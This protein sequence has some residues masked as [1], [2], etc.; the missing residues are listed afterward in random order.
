MKKIVLSAFVLAFS[1]I[2]CKSNGKFPTEQQQTS[3]KT[4][5]SVEFKS[6]SGYFARN[7]FVAAKDVNLLLLNTLENFDSVLGIAKT[8]NN[9]I[10]KP[11]FENTLPLAI[12]LKPT[13]KQTQLSI[14]KV[15]SENNILRIDAKLE[16]GE[17]Q[18]Y[19]MVPT[20][21]FSVPKAADTKEIQLFI[22]GTQ[23]ETLH[24]K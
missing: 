22:N 7:T 12:I 23:T 2:S 15:S 1:F 8:M 18:S 10:N 4:T 16:Q 21:V 5:T 13:D 9:K 6:L 14:D 24:L 17:K 3:Q 11:D 20:L 19:T